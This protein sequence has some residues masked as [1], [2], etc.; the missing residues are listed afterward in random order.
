MRNCILREMWYVPIERV[1]NY[2]LVLRDMKV[3]PKWF[4]K[5]E[6][7]PKTIYQCFHTEDDFIAF[8]VHYGMQNYPDPDFV[9]D[10]S[11]G[12][13]L[14]APLRPDPYHEKASPGQPKFFADTL[15]H[16]KAHPVGMAVA[17]TGTGKTA[18]ALNF[19]AERGRSALICVDRE[20][21]GFEQWI[22][23][24]KMKLG[25]KDEQIGIIQGDR[26]D[27]HK[28]FCVGIAASLYSRV[29]PPEC[30]RAFGTIVFDELHKFGAPEM[31]RILHMFSPGASMGQTATVN[32]KD[33]C[34]KLYIDHFGNAQIESTGQ[35]LRCQ[36]RVVDYHDERGGKLGG[37]HG[38]RMT[39]LA[40]DDARN[41]I[42]VRE[43]IKMYNE[44]RNILVIGDDIK[45]LQRLETMCWKAGVKE[46]RTGQF[47]RERYIMTM[48]PGEHKGQKVVIKRQKK[49]R[50]TNEYLNWVKEH[51]RII[52]G[53]YGMIKEGVDIPRLDGG[54]DA[55]PRT[56]GR[57][58]IGRIRR[59]L[60]GKRVPLWVTIRDRSHY[61]LERYYEERLADY[62]QSN[63]ELVHD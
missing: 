34:H 21:L 45:H 48:E 52:F 5:N 47:S 8:P 31:Q 38:A 42:I 10:T 18:N 36:L 58:V 33:G 9:N 41:Q 22:P 62:L 30:Y 50:V 43:I 7:R 57:Q 25:I 24:A 19:I 29:Y 26:C 4:N 12:Q 23:E 55:T 15:A 59:P 54:I 1:P 60:P 3:E 61:A 63:V 13:A 46:D 56:E 2:Q 20:F 35:A 27:F 37:T 14:I 40:W 6:P 51:A 16:F 28:P 17:G 49:A 53:T 39:S 44:G 11:E 32:R